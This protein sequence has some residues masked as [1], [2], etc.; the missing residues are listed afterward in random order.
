MNQASL[1]GSVLTSPVKS[2]CKDNPLGTSSICSFGTA[3]NFSA[4]AIVV[5][6]LQAFVLYP[7]EAPLRRKTTCWMSAKK[8]I[9]A[10]R[11]K[12]KLNHVGCMLRV[13]PKDPIKQ[14]NA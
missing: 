13:R 1:K 14:T 9:I 3:C 7:Q 10:N 11:L 12:T 6:Y 2:A 5:C 8:Q 4:V